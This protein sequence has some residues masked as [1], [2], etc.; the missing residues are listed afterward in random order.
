MGGK[1]FDDCI[2]TIL[3]LTS[4]RSIDHRYQAYSSM[5]SELWPMPGAGCIIYGLGD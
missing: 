5:M 1:G 2:Y 4:E 3:N